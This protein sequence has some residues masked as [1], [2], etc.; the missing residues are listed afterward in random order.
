MAERKYL[1]KPE[2]VANTDLADLGPT[3]AGSD[4]LK[5]LAIQD[6]DGRARTAVFSDVDNTFFRPDRADASFKLLHVLRGDEIPVI[7][8]T[9]NDFSIIKR[10]VESGIL[11]RFHVVIGSAGTEI[12]VLKEQDG[13]E[14]YV[15][16]PVYEKRLKDQ[17]YDRDALEVQGQKFIEASKFAHP[18]W[19][20]NFQ[21]LDSAEDT[22]AAGADQV[23]SYQPFKLSFYG[24]AASPEE[25]EVL[26][27]QFANH[28]SGRKVLTCEEINYNSRLQPG[29]NRK[30]YCLDVMAATK[31]D[32]VEYFAGKAGILLKVTAGDNENDVDMLEREGDVAI[33]VGGATPGLV[34]EMDGFTQT[35]E[36]GRHFQRVFDEK[37]ELQKLV[38]RERGAFLGPESIDR[39]VR[40]L[41][42]ILRISQRIKASKDK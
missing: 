14:Q 20:L 26:R 33:I 18:E 40:N 2:G 17:G 25:F 9:G 8:V 4:F 19:S 36:V 41:R 5:I 1:Q 29:D 15:K 3:Y 24:Y 42:S 13:F 37:G 21:Y 31:A 35:S 10:K 27:T 28:F 6:R 7:A 22:A 12:W 32:A 23:P 30:K 11:P 39:A 16:D 34:K 38:Y